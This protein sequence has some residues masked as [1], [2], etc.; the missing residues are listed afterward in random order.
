MDKPLTICYGFYF[1]RYFFSPEQ[2]NDC[3]PMQLTGELAPFEI[4]TATNSLSISAILHIAVCADSICQKLV[5][6]PSFS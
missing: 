4:K 2:E 1:S 6:K 5:P 3:G